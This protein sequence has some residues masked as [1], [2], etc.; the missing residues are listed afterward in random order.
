M[1]IL[2][3]GSGKMGAALYE[4]WLKSG[5]AKKDIVIVDPVSELATYKNISELPADYSPQ[6]VIIAVKPQSFEEIAQQLTA[7]SNACFVSI[8]AGKT[9]ANISEF[10]KNSLVIRTMPNLPATIG[11]GVIAAVPNR[12]LS[13]EEKNSLFDLLEPCGKLVWLKKESELDVVTALSG[14]G[15]A[16]IFLFADS[17]IEAGIKLGLDMDVASKLVFETIKGSVELAENS[18]HSLQ[19]L[20][21]NVTSKGGTTEAALKVLERSD[22]LKN[23]V[24]N[25]VKEAHSRSKELSK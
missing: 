2:L 23:L 8:M 25:A 18:S 20:K 14:S 12:Q 4:G 17:M 11:R 10:L 15:P 13:T 1:K 24:E 3:I 9:I 5:I 7:Y 19:K 16:Y 6:Y 21:T 22:I